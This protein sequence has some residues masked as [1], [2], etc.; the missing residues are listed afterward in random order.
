MI[1][2]KCKIIYILTF[3]KFLAATDLESIFTF[4]K[5]QI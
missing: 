5:V 1:D 3:L 2:L 4:L